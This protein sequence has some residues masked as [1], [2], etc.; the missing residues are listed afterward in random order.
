LPAAILGNVFGNPLDQKFWDLNSPFELAKKNSASLSRTKIYFDCGT[1][2]RY[3]FNRGA[4]ELDQTLG[5]L[6]IPHE[7]HLYPGGHTV[8]YLIAHR[9][10]SFE[11]H[12][13]EF[14]SAR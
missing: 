1:E 13:R 3:G 12:W 4:G 7:F 5:S 14:Q 9:G 6:K 10:A 8:S 2:D 11:F